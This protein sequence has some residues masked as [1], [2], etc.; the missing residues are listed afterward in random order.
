MKTDTLILASV[1]AVIAAWFLQ[2]MQG[3][4]PRWLQ[5][6][7]YNAPGFDAYRRGWGGEES[8]DS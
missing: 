6:G 8:G 5:S 4:A 3:S 1:A 7:V 2:R